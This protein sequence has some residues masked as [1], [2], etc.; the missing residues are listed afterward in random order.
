ML[1]VINKIIKKSH[2]PKSHCNV[3]GTKFIALADY[4]AMGNSEIS[5]REGATVELKKL[6]CA[7][8]V[9]V[10]KLGRFGFFSSTSLSCKINAGLL[11]FTLLCF[12]SYRLSILSL[13]S[14]KFS[15]TVNDSEKKEFHA[16]I[17]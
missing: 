5:M 8:W 2:S 3:K 6:G 1:S 13:R 7:G 10:K 15:L 12:D 14:K 9:Y 17:N 11:F 4:N 16:V